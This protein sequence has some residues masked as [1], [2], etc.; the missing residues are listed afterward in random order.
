M[1]RG[2]RIYQPFMTVCISRYLVLA[3]DYISLNISI[4]KI[5]FTKLRDYPHLGDLFSGIKKEDGKGG[6]SFYAR[7]MLMVTSFSEWFRGYV[8]TLC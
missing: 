6:R 7:R 4:G 1:I 5:C 3:L 8:C 2:K